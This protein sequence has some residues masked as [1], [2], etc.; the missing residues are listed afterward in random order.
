[1]CVA[2]HHGI[3]LPP[4]GLFAGNSRIGQNDHFFSV[5]LAEV[6]DSLFFHPEDGASEGEVSLHVGGGVT[7]RR[8]K[9]QALE[10][11]G[12]NSA[13]PREERVAESML[14]QELAL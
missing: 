8:R 14:C 5:D 10:R 9:V 6:T 13:F 1:M 3:S 4:G 12:G 2:T 11:W 7:H